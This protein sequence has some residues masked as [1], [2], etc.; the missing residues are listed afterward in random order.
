M[1]PEG[2]N[3]CRI[4]VVTI[5]ASLKTSFTKSECASAMMESVELDALHHSFVLYLRPV[6]MFLFKNADPPTKGRQMKYRIIN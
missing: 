5:L 6:D 3:A 4:L 2:R 1:A